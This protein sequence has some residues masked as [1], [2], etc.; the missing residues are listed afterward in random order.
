[1]PDEQ[2]KPTEH[3]ST[4]RVLSILE[5]LSHEGEKEGMTLSELSRALDAPK[6][7]I[8]PIV[9]TMVSRGFVEYDEASMR[10]SI[11]LM[12]LLAGKSYERS[13]DKAR[14]LESAMH[15][16]VD[17]C[18]ET[19]QLGVL[20]RGRALYIAKVEST[21]AIGLKSEVGKSL[22]VH[23]TAI[24]KAL[25]ADY[26][27]SELAVLLEEPFAR[28]TPNTITTLN[29]LWSQVEL[30]KRQGLA[31][32]AGELTPEV[33]CVATPLRIHG[34]VAY[35]IGV[36]TPAFRFTPEKRELIMDTLT[37]AR[38]KLERALT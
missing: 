4:A 5:L 22:P 38:E 31:F 2:T 20:D 23:C 12:T 8:L 32:D 9:R 19:C 1:M 11:G 24:G 16:I 29:E 28:F 36:S 21:E 27:R 6:S 7:S 37:Q 34:K 15:E 17:R 26:G 25:L 35:G 14:L 3:R 18:G 33:D 13:N 30:I 10:Y